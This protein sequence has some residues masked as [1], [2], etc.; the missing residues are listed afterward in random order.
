MRLA[1]RWT[2]YSTATLT[3]T[4]RRR[5]RRRR[6]RTSSEECGFIPPVQP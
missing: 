2:R 3:T 6:R 4:T 5:R 1:P